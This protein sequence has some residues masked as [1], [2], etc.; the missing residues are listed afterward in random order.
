MDKN[1]ER[2]RRGENKKDQHIAYQLQASEA[3]KKKGDEIMYRQRER[4]REIEEV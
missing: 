2:G 1:R 3:N 4:K